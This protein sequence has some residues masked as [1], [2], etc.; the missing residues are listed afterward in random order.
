MIDDLVELKFVDQANWS[1][2]RRDGVTKENWCEYSFDHR[3]QLRPNDDRNIFI[4]TDKT[5]E[6]NEDH[7]IN[8]SVARNIT[9]P[10]LDIRLK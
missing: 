2:P 3:F 6:V 4:F 1:S 5:I 7:F 10:L 8:Q 9:F